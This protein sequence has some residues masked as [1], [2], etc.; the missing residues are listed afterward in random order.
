MSRPSDKRKDPEYDDNPEWTEQTF[1]K[2]RSATEVLPELFSKEQADEMLRP[3]RGRPKKAVPKQ[4]VTLRLDADM[5]VKFRR[6]GPGWQ[7]QMN[8]ILREH[9]H[10]IDP[11]EESD[12]TTQS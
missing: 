7:T 1:A 11:P 12:S 2:A 3:K 6:L 5:L 9:M 8:R 10:E 4:Q